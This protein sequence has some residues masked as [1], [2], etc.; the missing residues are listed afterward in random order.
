MHARRHGS[1]LTVIQKSTVKGNVLM[2]N[3]EILTSDRVKAYV[4]H[5]LIDARYGCNGGEPYVACGKSTSA[6]HFSGHD[7]LIA[8]NLSS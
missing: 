4:E 3:G 1:R 7:P 2:K 6:P 5:A 8:N